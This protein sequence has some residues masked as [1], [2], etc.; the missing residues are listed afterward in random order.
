MITKSFF[1]KRST[2]IYLSLFLIIFIFMLLI[3]ILYNNLNILVGN[4]FIK[5]TLAYRICDDECYEELASSDMVANIKKSYLSDLTIEEDFLGEFNSIG[6]NSKIVFSENKNLKDNEVILYYQKEFYK[7]NKNVIDMI[8]IIHIDG[9]EYEVKSIELDNYISHIEVSSNTLNKYNIDNSYIYLFNLKVKDQTLRDNFDGV[10]ILTII[11][12]N[13]YKVAITLNKY[14]ETTKIFILI[15]IV[16]SIII[17]GVIL[18]NLFY[19]FSFSNKLEKY[20][21]FSKKKRRLNCYVR[22]TS[23][24][25]S[26][27]L[28]SII[29]VLLIC[30]IVGMFF[31][32]LEMEF[33][34]LIILYFAII[35]I[36]KIIFMFIIPV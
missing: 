5:S 30:L 14:L 2:K 24:I 12:S 34:Y 13:E 6:T 15:I 23:L 10:H 26:A 27:F 9:I 28:L 8:K 4:N 31:P 22:I 35:E 11:S 19:D 29:L 36:V 16:V 7:D 18:S 25:A 32:Y 21:G 1:R 20:I 17:Y 3:N 33:N